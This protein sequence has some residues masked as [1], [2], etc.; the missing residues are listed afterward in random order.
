[1]LPDLDAMKLDPSPLVV[2]ICQV[3]YEQSLVVSDAET[4]FKIHEELG[5]KNGPYQQIESVQTMAAQIEIGPFGLG[6]GMPAGLQ[7][8]GWR[9][10][11]EDGAWTI[12]IFPDN[13]A[14]ET[15]AYQGWKADFKERFRT[16]LEAIAK[17]VNPSL[18]QRV[19]LRYAN[20]IIEN[21]RKDPESWRDVIAP[22][23]LSPLDSQ[24]W[25][26]GLLN[27][28]HQIFLDVGDDARCTV[29]HGFISDQA[30]LIDSYALDYDVFRQSIRR[31]DVDQIGASLSHFHRVALAIFKQSLTPEYLEG[32]KR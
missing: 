11:S 12:T 7:A 24:F 28:Q 22:E 16:L 32:L 19:G 25:A 20:R 30:G 23:L 13:V 10:R 15:T 8:S 14:L 6:Q 9:L 26:S 27:A 2:V 17:H 31:F 1:M 5:G 29:K 18:E 3:R 21:S 4:A